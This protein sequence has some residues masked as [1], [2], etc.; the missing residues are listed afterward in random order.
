MFE[1]IDRTKFYAPPSLRLVSLPHK[2]S[3]HTWET[4]GCDVDLSVG[5]V[6][7]LYLV[8]FLFIIISIRGVKRY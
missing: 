6:M 3:I 8:I 1:Q 4:E 2:M 5:D 7:V